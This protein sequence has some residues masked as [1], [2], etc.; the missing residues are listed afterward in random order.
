MTSSV[1]RLAIASGI[2]PSSPYPTSIRN[3]R[4]CFATTSKTPSSIPLRPSFHCSA[5]RIEYCSRV[6]GAVEGSLRTHERIHAR[7][8]LLRAARLRG[9]GMRTELHARWRRDRLFVFDA[10]IGLDLVTE[11][12]GREIARE[13]TYRHVVILHR[14]D[15]TIARDGDAV[16][17]ALELRLQITE[18]GV[19][20]E[21][22]IILG[23]GEQTRQGC[24]Q[25]ALCLLETREGLFV[26][27]E[28]GCL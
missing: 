19:G 12:H 10:E 25:F 17:R 11:H 3:A 8:T 21:L 14:L 6:S 13:G 2:T 15:I 22:R 18:Q 4:S 27:D 23:D 1:T 7:D 5:T 26:I 20:L 9:A 24:G 28:L 16:L